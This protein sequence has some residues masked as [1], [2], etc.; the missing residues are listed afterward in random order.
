VPG[1]D[2][3]ME[4]CKSGSHTV[5]DCKYHVVWV[6]KYRYPELSGDVWVSDAENCYARQPGRMRRSVPVPNAPTS[7]RIA[8]SATTAICGACLD[9]RSRRRRML[10]RSQDSHAEGQPW[11]G[12][13]TGRNKCNSTRASLRKLDRCVPTAV[14][15]SSRCY[16]SAQ[17][18]ATVR[19]AWPW[20]IIQGLKN[21][22]WPTY[23]GPSMRCARG[24][25]W[26]S[27]S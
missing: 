9:P 6:T 17:T 10:R 3:G 26:R 18:W 12:P 27:L 14:G 13:R 11:F 1:V 7:A 2:G 24:E 22:L 19:S 20:A 8:L 15:H 23:R 5:W 25:Q 4:S 21:A 16:G